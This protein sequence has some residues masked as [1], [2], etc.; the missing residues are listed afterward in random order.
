MIAESYSTGQAAKICKVAARTV[1]KWMDSGKLKGFRLPGPGGFRRVP[2]AALV[3]FMQQHHF[4]L[5]VLEGAAYDGWVD[6]R[7]KL[8][9]APGDYLVC[10][11]NLSKRGIAFWSADNQSW[12][13]LPDDWQSV[14]HWRSYPT[15]PEA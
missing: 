14:T 11:I 3:A 13:G 6:T 15:L 7:D 2:H 10:S 5:G 1:T 9:G 8:P 4:P 12:I